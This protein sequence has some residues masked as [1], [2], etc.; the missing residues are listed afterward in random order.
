MS[1]WS[2]MAALKPQYV[3]PKLNNQPLAVDAEPSSKRLKT[4]ARELNEL[5]EDTPKVERCI[6]VDSP[7]VHESK[8]MKKKN[9][10]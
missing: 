4:E 5:R 2:G 3:L 1:N 7:G 9:R 8:Q 6:S 10:G